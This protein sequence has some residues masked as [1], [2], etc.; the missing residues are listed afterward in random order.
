MVALGI[1]LA[2]YL[3]S[4]F[5]GEAEGIS[6]IGGTFRIGSP[7]AEGLTSIGGTCRIGGMDADGLGEHLDSVQ[8]QLQERVDIMNAVS[9]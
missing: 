4:G 6:T 1:A 8:N 5:I 7:D 3:P 2:T 9:P